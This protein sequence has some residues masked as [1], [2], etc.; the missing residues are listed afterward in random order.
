MQGIMGLASASGFF[1][2]RGV[3]FRVSRLRVSRFSVLEMWP[4]PWV[5]PPLPQ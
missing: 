1:R 2:V 4:R 5:L 3:E